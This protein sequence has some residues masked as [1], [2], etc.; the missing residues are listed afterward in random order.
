MTEGQWVLLQ[1]CHLAASW[2]NQL[3]RI[4]E[5]IDPDRVSSDFRLWLTSMPSKHFPVSVLQNGVKMTNEPP[6]GLRA[7]LK[8]FFFTQNDDSMSITNNPYAYRKLLFGLAFFHANVQ[9]RKK[10]GPLGWNKPY[11]FNNSDMEISKRQLEL[12]LDEYDEIP[13]RVLNFLTSYINYG[14]RVTDDKDLRTI[15]VILKDYFCEDAMEDGYRFSP[16]GVYVSPEMDDDL[17]HKSAIDYINSLPINPDPEVFGMHSN[18]NITCDRNETFDL[19][20]T[21]LSLQPRSASG[22]GRSRDDIIAET[23]MDILGRLPR[24]YDVEA[25]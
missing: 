24:T 4:C 20:D 7:N 12:Y 6:K 21:L 23:A 3:E 17:P 22:G 15:D 16:S 9:E 2:M 1:N 18:A 5:G 25:I 10:F 8:N 13:Y 19:F 11:E 14:G